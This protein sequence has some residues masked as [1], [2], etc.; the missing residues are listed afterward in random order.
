MTTLAVDFVRGDPECHYK[1]VTA[2]VGKNADPDA[3]DII[4]CF[5]STD[6]PDADDEVMLPDGVDLSRYTKNPVVML[7]HAMGQ[8]GCYYPLPVGRCEWTQKRPRGVQAGVRFTDKSAMG[9]EVKALFDDDMLRSFS[10][11]FRPLEVSGM[12]RKEAESR[13]DWFAAFERTKGRIAV[14]RR[15]HMIELSVA[16]VPSN[17]DALVTRYKSKGILVP[18]WLKVPPEGKTMSTDST[19]QGALGPTPRFDLARKALITLDEI[20]AAAEAAGY[21][22]SPESGGLPATEVT[23]ADARVMIGLWLPPETARTV[24]VPG[25][26]A[27]ESL[28]LTL[29]YLGRVLEVGT[30]AIDRVKRM[31]QDVAAYC[32]VLLGKLAGVGRFGAS[33]TSDGKD[34]IYASA[35]IPDL[36]EFRQRL[37]YNL[38]G[39]GVAYSKAHGFTPHVTLA[40]V[41]PAES[42][43]VERIEPTPVAFDRLCLVVDGEKTFFPFTTAGYGYGGPAMAWRAAA[44]AITKGLGGDGKPCDCGKPDCE[45][46]GEAARAGEAGDSDSDSEPEPED[47]SD[48]SGEPEPEESGGFRRYDPVDVKAPHYKGF[49]RIE[50]IHTKGHVPHVEDDVI[51]TREKPL[52]C[53]KCFRAKGDGFKPTDHHVHAE[54]KHL[55]KRV[56]PFKAPSKPAKPALAA[57][58]KGMVAIDLP[59]LVELSPTEEIAL[60]LA[61]LSRELDSKAIKAMAVEERER[62]EGY[63]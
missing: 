60:A 22:A 47:D 40:Y 12:T 59:P 45:E 14:H 44:D 28:H 42:S 34:V 20:D 41:D 30:N 62:Q 23:P 2:S 3:R 7:C 11:G 6:T 61:K 10:V 57:R 46:C 49:G 32:P 13:P 26:E 58:P 16:P 38:E 33:D 5:M 1:H 31:C 29:C 37:A 8:P 15:W 48:D 25:G 53:V 17:P 36:A 50:S 55:T 24:A 39:M 63:V 18:D 4:P 21:V 35:D 27:P 51:A 56:E 54:M 9:R 52:A 19:D 43:P